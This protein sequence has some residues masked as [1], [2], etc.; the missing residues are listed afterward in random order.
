[1]TES[2]TQSRPNQIPIQCPQCGHNYQTPIVSIV[3]VGTNPQLRS[4]FLANQ[5]NVGVCPQCQTPVMLEVPL[6]YHDPKAE[7]LAIYFPQQLNIPEMEK[8]KMIGELTQAMMRS[9]PPE[10]RKGYFLSPRQFA[11]RQSM[12]DAVY[13]T[14]GVS[15]EELD[16]QR[17]K[18]KLLEQLVV[19]AD[20]PKGL[21]MMIKGN[22][23]QIDGEFFS[24]LSAMLEQ[25]RALNDEKG[26]GRLEMLRENLLPVTTWGRKAQKQRAAIESL[27]DVETAEEFLDKV[28]AAD[29][30]VLGAIALAARPSL[31][32]AFFQGLTERVDSATGDEK[33]RL[34]RVRDTLLGLTQQ[35]D[36]AARE[37]LESRV[38]L[39]HEMV[40]S[41]NPR[42]AVHEH[43]DELDDMFMSILTRN[44]EAAE[45]KG[46]TALLQRLGMIYDEIMQM[47]QDSAPPE[48]RFINDLLMEPYP[49]GTRSFLQTHREAVSPEFVDLLQ[50]MADDM[51][52]QEGE[53]AAEMVKRLRD[54]RSQAML[55]I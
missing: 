18:A 55:M 49:D 22:D 53:E 33:T 42:S 23:P 54:I 37:E 16:R 29:E 48:V 19:F 40:N 4:L 31:D 34:A 24:I 50:Q 2:M 8:Q 45:K 52:S 6:V 38:K 20:D 46:D 11:S 35:M 21:Q 5:L 43:M 9:L 32:Y 10:Q 3:D 13:G 1:M 28:V 7:F 41:Q 30:D 26:A 15:Q 51:A 25:A 14:M 36:D 17:R 44:L 47:V 27:Q 39:L 12:T